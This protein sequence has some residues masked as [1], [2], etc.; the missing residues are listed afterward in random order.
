MVPQLDDEP[1]LLV[2][3]HHV[4]AAL[5]LP[6]SWVRAKTRE[7]ELP[8]VALGRYRR[9][10]LDDVRRWVETRKEGGR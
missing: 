8:S 6:L 5:D 4:A 3:A 7:G 10:A 1:R 2:D 9:Y